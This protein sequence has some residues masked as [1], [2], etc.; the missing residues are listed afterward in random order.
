M[1]YFKSLTIYILFLLLY[2]IN[3][4]LTTNR[5]TLLV[6]SLNSIKN[7][8][9]KLILK[10]SNY[11]RERRNSK[12]N[13]KLFKLSMVLNMINNKLVFFSCY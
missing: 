2:N 13:C 12:P 8:N 5:D 1:V 10:N 7:D 9:Q 6:Q 3:C 11:N 4:K